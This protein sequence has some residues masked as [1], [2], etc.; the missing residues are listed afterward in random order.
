MARHY[1]GPPAGANSLTVEGGPE[2]A[3]VSGGFLRALCRTMKK[4]GK[5][6]VALIVG[7]AALTVTG[8]A[9]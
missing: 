7:V 2:A 9:L 1:A 3:A 4:F 5:K 8:S 6:S